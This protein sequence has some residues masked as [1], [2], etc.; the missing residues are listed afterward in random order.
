LTGW[1]SD[2]AFEPTRQVSLVAEPRLPRDVN[3]SRARAQQLRGTSH[4]RV[5]EPCIRRHPRIRGKQARQVKR[6]E[7]DVDG[8]RLAA[9]AG[10]SPSATGLAAPVVR[11][12]ALDLAGGGSGP[13][14]PGALAAILAAFLASCHASPLASGEGPVAWPADE[15]A[16]VDASELRQ[17]GYL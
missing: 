13:G 2:H 9:R 3:D 15:G 1:N 6:T 5:L 16:L 4:A 17:I 7:C 11:V 8:E 12:E 10:G 14:N